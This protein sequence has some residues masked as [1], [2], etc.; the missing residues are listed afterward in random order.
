M[1]HDGGDGPPPLLDEGCLLGNNLPIWLTRPEVRY[2]VTV[3]G[4]ITAVETPDLWRENALKGCAE[5]IA[6]P[7]S[8]IGNNLLDSVSPFYKKLFAM[9]L[10]RV[11][12][13]KSSVVAWRYCADSPGMCRHFMLWVS[14]LPE[15]EIAFSSTQLDEHLRQPVFEEGFDDVDTSA[16]EI[17][18]WCQKLKHR[19]GTKWQSP[20]TFHAAMT[21]LGIAP[22]RSLQVK[23]VA[24]ETCAKELSHNGMPWV[25][26]LPRA[27]TDTHSR[28]TLVC[29]SA[30]HLLLRELTVRVCATRPWH[31]MTFPVTAKRTTES[32][33]NVG[34]PANASLPLAQARECVRV[35]CA[36]NPSCGAIATDETA[37]AQWL[38]GPGGLALPVIGIA[39]DEVKGD[40]LTKAG[41]SLIVRRPQW[42]QLKR[43]LSEIAR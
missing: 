11:E 6:D 42:K 3:D 17:C 35:F 14:R 37:I 13:G 16:V 15:G 26:Y 29:V 5:T 1:S 19:D 25:P 21:Q 36:N 24:C 10:K 33:S 7:K 12:E 43:A 22:P 31:A 8:V 28:M 38:L 39:C 4:M 30:D 34:P 41:C 18:G 2:R 20:D 27:V 9:V 23:H 40:A 32:E